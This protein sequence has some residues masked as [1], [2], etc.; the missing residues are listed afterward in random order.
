[1]ETA[2]SDMVQ[3][4]LLQEQLHNFQ[5]LGTL[6]FFDLHFGVLFLEFVHF[7]VVQLLKVHS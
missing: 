3:I 1:M 4:E 2:L 7:H 5:L 6:I